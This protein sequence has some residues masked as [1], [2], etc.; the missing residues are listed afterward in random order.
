M[1][2]KRR[3]ALFC[4]L[5][6]L[7]GALFA[8]EAVTGSDLSLIIRD[9]YETAL[10]NEQA[11]DFEQLEADLLD[12]AAH[13][14]NL[15]TATQADLEQLFFLRPEQIDALLLYV[16]ENG[17][18]SVYELQLLPNWTRYEIRDVLPFVVVEPVEKKEPF[19][20]KEMWHQGRHEIDLRLDGRKLESYV[21]DPMYASLKYQFAYRKKVKFGITMER[22]A[23]EPWWGKKTYGFDFYSGFLQINDLNKQV[24]KLFLGDFRAQ[25][26]LGLVMGNALQ[27]GG[28]SVG[29]M[30]N[31]RSALTRYHSTAEYDFFRGAG[32][33]FQLGKV[34][35]MP[36][37]SA[38]RLDGHPENG[39]V[40]SLAQ[41]GYH[42]TERERAGKMQVWQ[43]V[44]GAHVQYASEQW[45]V[46]FTATGTFL[47]DTLKPALNYYNTDYFRGKRQVAMGL[48]YRWRTRYVLLFGE[49]ATCSNRQWGWANITGL[50]FY[51]FSKFSLVAMY[52]YYSPFYDTFFAHAVGENGR[53]NDENGL[54]L[55]AETAALENT[56]LSL[57][58]DLFRFSLPKYTIPT[59]SE[60]YEVLAQVD[61]AKEER[62][63]MQ[64]RL[65]IKQ[66]GELSR[67]QLRYILHNQ[68]GGFGFRTHLEGSIAKRVGQR[69]TWGAMLAQDMSYQFKQVPIRLQLRLEGFYAPAYDNRFYL[70]ENDVLYAFSVPALYGIGA[71][72]YL[73]L[74]YKINEHW[75]LYF[76]FSQTVYAEQWQRER[77]LL[78]NRQTDLHLL[79]RVKL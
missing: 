69:L 44:V 22:D 67:Y 39:V 78:H 10:E 7:S 20:W 74:R 25:F 6:T 38:R 71:R 28:K 60:G 40:S 50:R 4:L 79:V 31:M 3:I 65:R 24:R 30:G 19:S 68:T 5:G 26:G 2:V 17:M 13:P 33:E 63:R 75:A 54:Y 76:R 36:F 41:T 37:Y 47:S 15:L 51:P 14:I 56:R 45:L 59:P 21:G 61:W 49:V 77:A 72:Y 34:K 1:E 62:M 53:N 55:G 27:L 66:K 9:I 57:Y 43:Q 70:Y 18:H 52:R 64:G 23:G 8:Q 35:V 29:Q 11:V 46:G 12:L 16:Y 73:N 32:A 42:R 48:N 58:V